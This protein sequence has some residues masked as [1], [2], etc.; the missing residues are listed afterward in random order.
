MQTIYYIE[1]L[2]IFQCT[3]LK[4]PH[5]L[6]TTWQTILP[7]AELF[8]IRGVSR[9]SFIKGGRLQ[10]SANQHTMRRAICHG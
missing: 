5:T 6:P 7:R 1:I 4:V 3:V 10:D 2:P 9:A 8:S